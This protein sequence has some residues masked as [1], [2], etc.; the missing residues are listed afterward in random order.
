MDQLLVDDLIDLHLTISEFHKE[1][2]SMNAIFVN[3]ENLTEHLDYHKNYF[4]DGYWN[5]E[6]ITEKFSS[7]ILFMIKF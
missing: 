5:A 2:I 7:W 4:N 3:E 6:R 1:E